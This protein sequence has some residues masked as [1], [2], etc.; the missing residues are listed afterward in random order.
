MLLL[1]PGMLLDV[2]AAGRSWHHTQRHPPKTP[3]AAVHCWLVA[4]VVPTLLLLQYF[5]Q[6]GIGCGTVLPALT[7]QLQI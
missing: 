5:A 1:R 2:P 3:A 4:L 6:Q 7:R